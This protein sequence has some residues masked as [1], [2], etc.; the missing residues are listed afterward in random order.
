MVSWSS[1]ADDASEL[2][3]TRKWYADLYAAT[4]GVPVPNAT[5]AGSYINYPDADLADPA[6]NRSGVPWHD[7]YYLGN[8]PRLRQIK[9]KWDPRN[10]FRHRMSI[11]PL[12]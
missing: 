3:W 9:T 8:Y 12:R 11:E 10:V 7:L 4:S 5:N 2:A 6:F 1:A